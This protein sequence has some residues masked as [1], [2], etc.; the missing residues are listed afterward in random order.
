MG[1]RVTGSARASA[2][3]LGG[4]RL[5]LG[6]LRVSVLTSQLLSFL[7]RCDSVIGLARN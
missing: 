3:I 6:L 1:R 5:S 2:V 4:L 7:F